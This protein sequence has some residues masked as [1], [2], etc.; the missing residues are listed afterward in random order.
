MVFKDDREAKIIVFVQWQDLEDKVCQAL[1]THG[2]RFARL[3]VNRACTATVLKRF[4][5]DNDAERVLVLSL[6]YSASGSNLTRANHIV[7]VHPMNADC[8]ANAVAYE[9]QAL[10]RIRRI[11]Q[12]RTEVHLWRFIATGTIEENLV[13]LHAQQEA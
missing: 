5:E 12:P 8:A 6:Q 3:P 11:G 2:I 1:Q 9:R 10:G 7:L 13:K 4:Q